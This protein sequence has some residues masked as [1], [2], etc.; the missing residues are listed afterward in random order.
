VDGSL[1]DV[2][3]Q[4]AGLMSP[5]ILNYRAN[6]LRDWHYFSNRVCNSYELT[7]ALGYQTT[8]AWS[9]ADDT[10]VDNPVYP[11]V[12]CC[13]CCPLFDT[14]RISAHGIPIYQQLPQQFFQSYIPYTF[15]GYNVNTPED[16][17]L[18]MVNFCLYPGTYQPSGHVN[19]SRAREF[20]IKFFVNVDLANK[21]WDFTTGL[22]SGGFSGLTDTN[23]DL[24]V[25][26]SALNFLL[27]SD[28]SAVKRVTARARCGFVRARGNAISCVT[29]ESWINMI[30]SYLLVICEGVLL[31]IIENCIYNYSV[32]TAAFTYCNVGENGQRYTF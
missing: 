14:I 4:H 30:H 32:T 31:F 25:V 9:N 10:V 12:E 8:N 7:G 20:Y 28:G 17:G 23:L 11:S 26:A 2:V 1:Q 29:N 15:G 22:V 6:D 21:G 27:I 5:G 19:V 3:A 13:E 24:I 18:V 16:C